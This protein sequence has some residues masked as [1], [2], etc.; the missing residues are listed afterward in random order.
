MSVTHDGQT[1]RGTILWSY[2]GYICCFGYEYLVC[3]DSCVP[4]G[5]VE[6][7]PGGQDPMTDG[8]SLLQ[9]KL[10]W[11]QTVCYCP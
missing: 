2:L 10:K 5:T 7:P 3:L 6:W 8:L 9:V 1:N 11:Y 4:D